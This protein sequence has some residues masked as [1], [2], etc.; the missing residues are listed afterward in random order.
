MPISIDTGNG[1]TVTFA[2]GFTGS[3]TEVGGTEQDIP[4]ILTSHLGTVAAHTYIAGDLYEPGEFDC[5]IIALP[6]LEALTAGAGIPTLGG[7]AFTVTV[8][9]PVSTGMSTGATLA[10]TAYVKKRKTATLKNNE[11]MMH[12][13][14]IKWTGVT[15]P[16][17]TAAT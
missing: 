6:A 10:G 1:A 7:A 13:F 16:A 15:K 4:D 9:Y 3:Y 12:T 5:E 17:F 14:T 8:T 2:G 11:L